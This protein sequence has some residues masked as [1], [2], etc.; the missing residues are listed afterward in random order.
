[1]GLVKSTALLFAVDG[2]DAGRESA[3]DGA[4]SLLGSKYSKK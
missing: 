2:L 4:S 1:M 3:A